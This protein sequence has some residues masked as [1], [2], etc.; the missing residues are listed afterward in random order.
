[1]NFNFIGNEKVKEQLAFLME[2]QRLPHAI[3]IEGD[4]GLG[5]RTL[6]RE[7]AL[8]LFCRSVGEKPCR[9]CPQCKKALKGYH[10]DLYEYSAAGGARSFHVDVVRKVRD[11]VFIRPN[12]AQY[13]VYIL[14]NCQC[15]SESA[16]NAILKILEEPP[17]YA[18][19]ILTVNNKSAL[20]ETVLSRSVVVSLESVDAKKGAEYICEKMPDVD[21]ADALSAVEVW[22]GNIGKAVES[23]GEGRLSKISAIACNMAEALT[24]PDEYELLKVCSAFERDRETLIATL[25][26]LKTILRDALVCGTGADVL[27]GQAEQAKRLSSDLGKGRLM[28]LITTCDNMISYAEKN[29]SNAILITKVCYELRRAQNR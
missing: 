13:K 12:E 16:Q 9:E 8:A 25:S 3:V 23:L 5:K 7:I 1:M 11:D 21:F 6:A 2:S 20:L 29:G 26:L 4:E 15:M 18:V 10:P 19:F 24:K 22:G 28:R 17:S 27:S 14:G